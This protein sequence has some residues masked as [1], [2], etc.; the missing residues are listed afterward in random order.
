MKLKYLSIV[1]T[2]LFSWVAASQ[3]AADAL[4]MPKGTVILSISGA[5][6]HSNGQGVDGDSVANFDRAMLEA[7]P[8]HQFSTETPWTDGSH[9]YQG[10]LLSVLLQ[11]VGASGKKLVARALN[12]YHSVIDLA[13]IADYPVILAYA[14]DGQ[15]MRVRDKGPLWVLYPMSDFPELNTTFHHAGM[16]WQLRHLE[17]R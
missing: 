15:A 2:L 12:D 6:A 8:R 14:A 11:H 4:P 1:L 16:V 17:V 13:P 5:I 10:V 7:L 3:A 9:Q